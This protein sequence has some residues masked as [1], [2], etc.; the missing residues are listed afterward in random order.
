[1]ADVTQT[2]QEVQL[3][4]PLTDAN[5]KL[6]EM[7]TAQVVCV[8]GDFLYQNA[9]GNW[10]LATADGVA[11][12]ADPLVDDAEAMALTPAVDAQDTIMIA[13]AGL[14]LDVGA[15]LSATVEYVLSE[16]DGKIKDKSQLVSGEYYTHLGSGDDNGYLD[17]KPFSSGVQEP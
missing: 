8:Q 5:K 1:M 17:F 3:K 7:V 13:K 12:G 2:R 9:A 6:V 4:S 14:K 10:D 16:N 11:V 15:T